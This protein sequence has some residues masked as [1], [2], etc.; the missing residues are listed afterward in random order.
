MIPNLRRLWQLLTTSERRKFILVLGM[1]VTMAALETIGV[2]SIMPFL[3]VLGDPDIVAEQSALRVLYHSLGFSDTQQFVLALG[4]ASATIVALS[5]LFKSVTLHALNRFANLQRHSISSRLLATYLDQ[6]YSFF[7]G[8]NSADL[9]RSLLSEVDQLVFNILQPVVQM[10]AH[11]VVLVAMILLLLLY[12]PWMAITVAAAIGMLYVVVYASVRGVLGRIG[13]DRERANTER[14]LASSEAFGA[15]KEVKVS[16]SMDAYLR[17]FDGPS[18]LFSRHLAT[19]E[20]L[21]Q[22]PLYIV[23][24]VGYAGLIAIALFLSMRGDNL[25]QVLPVLGLYGFAAYRLLPAAQ[26][27]YRSLARMRFGASA[28]ENI[29]RDMHLHRMGEAKVAGEQN[30]E[31]L[32][33][34]ES[35]VFDNVGFV[36]PGDGRVPALTRI[37]FC[38]PVGSTI[39]IVGRTGSGKSTLVDLLLGLLSPGTGSIYIDGKALIPARISSWQRAIGYVPQHIFIADASVAENIAIGTDHDLIDPGAIE[40]AARIAQIHDFVVEELPHGYQTKVGEGGVRLSGGQRQRIGIARALYRDPTVLILDEATSALDNITEQGVM[41]K[42]HTMGVRK[43]MLLITHR[44]ASIQGCDRIIVL[45]EG[46]IVE[47]G[48]YRHLIETSDRFRALAA[49]QGGL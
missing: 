45:E 19:N 2:V 34:Q 6:P 23:E 25:G 1:V 47:A 37:D 14:F 44:L 29:H 11:A 9:S 40:R 7:L 30:C 20:T 39:G 13:P 31:P 24:A 32:R 26:I 4:V 46:E 8:R 27:I 15:I 21:S 22:V 41:A 43:T 16:G 12:D 49:T 48:E 36:Y 28:L 3:S 18:R 38:I 33:F 42:I 5:S 35:I 17:R 10:L